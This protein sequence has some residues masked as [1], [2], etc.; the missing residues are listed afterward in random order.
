MHLKTG[1]GDGCIIVGFATLGKPRRAGFRRRPSLPTSLRLF[2]AGFSRRAWW[3][4]LPLW[5][6]AQ[7]SARFCSAADKL[8]PAIV[9]ISAWCRN[10]SRMAV[11]LGTSP[12][13]LPT[14]RRPI[15]GSLRT[16]AGA[17]ESV[18]P[19]KS[20]AGQWLYRVPMPTYRAPGIMTGTGGEASPPRL[21]P[22]SQA[23]LS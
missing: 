7:A 17:S 11:A 23:G 20:P 5:V 22:A 6:P 14:F 9:T 8:L 15:W 16:V 4:V 21:L 12:R 3:P 2:S 1:R 13:S 18:R 10:R 19:P